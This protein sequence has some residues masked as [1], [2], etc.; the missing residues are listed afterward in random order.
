MRR[1]VRVVV[2]AIVV[3]GLLVILY[4]DLDVVDG[5]T[6]PT[7]GPTASP[8]P[9]PTAS[10]ESGPGQ[11]LAT[12]EVT[13]EG[14]RG[15]YARDLFAHWRDPDDNGCDARQDAL[16]DQAL[17]PVQRDPFACHVVEGDWRSAYDGVD[18]SGPAAEVDIDHVVSLAEAWDSGASAWDEARREV[19]ANDPDNL[20]VVTAEVNRSKG[21]GDVAE[22]RPP[23]EGSWCLTATIVI[24]T[25]ARWE[26]SID[27]AERQWLD[28]MT[29]TCPEG[30]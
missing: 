15:G 20:L 3:A 17:G 2:M 7:T 10:P 8:G 13:Y 23:D 25:K 29:G 12:L 21:D 14:S 5:T 9:G 26:L 16:I 4:V 24:R 6:A 1:V 28:E 30:G 18:Y 27:P 19:F 11:L 22:W